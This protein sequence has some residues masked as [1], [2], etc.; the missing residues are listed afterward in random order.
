MTSSTS[1]APRSGSSPGRILVVDDDPIMREVMAAHFG[2]MGYAVTEAE[3]GEEACDLIGGDHF[4]LA[5]IDLSMPKLDGF[6]LLRYI[7]QH[8][9]TVDLPVI[10]VTSNNDEASIER[11]YDLGASSFVTKPVNWHLFGHHALFVMRNGETERALRTAEIE[12]T[13][14]SKMKNGLFQVLSHELKTPLTAM[15]G[16][17]DVLAASLRGRVE[18]MQAEQL[19]LVIDAAH[20]LN[21]IVSDILLLSKALAGQDRL[22]IAAVTVAELLDDSIVG[23]KARAK[24]RDITLLVRQPDLD[25]TVVCDAQL[26]RQALRKLVDNAVKFSNQGGTVEIWAHA[27]DD[28]SLVISVRDGGPGLSQAKLRECLQPFIQNDMS[29]GRPVDGR[30]L[31]LP[32]A[33][34][35]AEVHG[36]ELLCQTAPGQGMIAAIWLPARVK[37]SAITASRS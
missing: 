10:V 3:H 6:G 33:K 4:A 34:A 21:A 29:Y 37:S 13:S 30:G 24:A 17:T 16:L 28:G 11:A 14:A 8:P 25:M 19:D 23:L 7:R 5:V 31:G 26:M 1:Q 35:I 2:E 9:R 32:I 36:G 15:I 27:K 12:A 20:R 22:Q 18:G